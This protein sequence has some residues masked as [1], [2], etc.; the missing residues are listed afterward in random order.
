MWGRCVHQQRQLHSIEKLTHGLLLHHAMFPCLASRMSCLEGRARG[1]WEVVS[2][3]WSCMAAA[4]KSVCLC[5][6]S[7][8]PQTHVHA[9][10]WD[11]LQAT[12]PQMRSSH[13]EERIPERKHR[14]AEAGFLHGRLGV[15][16]LALGPNLS[17]SNAVMLTIQ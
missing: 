15:S 7:L 2:G 6:T 5:W 11:L 17:I 8:A 1:R 14:F 3:Y 13:V 4:V 10:L 9:C 12:D 16:R